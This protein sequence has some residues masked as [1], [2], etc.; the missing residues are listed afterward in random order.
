[1]MPVAPRAGI[2]LRASHVDEILALRP[3]LP[4]LEIHAENYM[5]GGPR[6]TK[7]D[8]I[9]R[10]YPISVHGVGLSVGTADRLDTNHLT[11]LRALIDRIDPCFV[12][13][14]LAWSTIG[15]AYLNHLLP[16]PYTERTLAVVATHVSE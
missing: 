13:E 1:M 8:G 9:R 6:L 15:G 14:H 5:G 7:L 16:L 11:R 3:N 2:G 10:D 12:S 4:W